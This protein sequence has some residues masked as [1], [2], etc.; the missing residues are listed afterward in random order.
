[1]NIYLKLLELSQSLGS[2]AP[3]AKL[4]IDQLA[5]YQLFQRYWK[6]L[7]IKCYNQNFG[8]R[9][10]KSSQNNHEGWQIYQ[11]LW[12][13]KFSK[14]L[15]KIFRPIW[16]SRYC[17][18]RSQQSVSL[19]S[20]W[21]YCKTCFSWFS[22]YDIGLNCQESDKLSQWCKNRLSLWPISWNPQKC[23]LRINARIS[24]I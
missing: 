3:V 11:L 24:F 7:L 14:E 8:F 10:G 13:Y 21:P 4:I 1:M 23:S 5:Y 19:T 22:Q 15:A 20:L 12:F 2:N 9:K 17:I 16:C 6:I 18:K